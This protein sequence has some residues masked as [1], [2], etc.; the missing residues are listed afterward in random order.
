MRRCSEDAIPQ[1][2]RQALHPAAFD[3][4]QLL[5]Q[6]L[7]FAIRARWMRVTAPVELSR[8]RIIAWLTPKCRAATV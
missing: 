3:S 7:A 6:V 8:N 2:G 4:P 5:P 1:K